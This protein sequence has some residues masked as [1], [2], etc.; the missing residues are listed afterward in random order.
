MMDSPRGRER[1][2]RVTDRGFGHDNGLHR[3]TDSEAIVSH[4]DLPSLI[5]ELASPIHQAVRFDYLA[6]FL[7]DAA[8]SARPVAPVPARWHST[9]GAFRAFPGSSGVVQNYVFSGN[10]TDYLRGSRFQALR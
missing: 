10:T 6:L 8:S 3:R 9:V 7:H 2:G 1:T 5:H 4:W